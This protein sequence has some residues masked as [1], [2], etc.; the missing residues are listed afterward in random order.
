[1]EEI[2]VENNHTGAPDSLIKEEEELNAAD[3][4]ESESM[5]PLRESY[6]RPSGPM[7]TVS[8]NVS[9]KEF[10]IDKEAIIL[11]GL[12]LILTILAIILIDA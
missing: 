8:F 1:M 11:A 3:A 9:G 4:R 7:G 2:F 6:P 12:C 10:G 5:P